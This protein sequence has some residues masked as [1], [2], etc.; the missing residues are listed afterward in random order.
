MKKYIKDEFNVLM[1]QDVWINA[2]RHARRSYNPKTGKHSEYYTGLREDDITGVCVDYW[3]VTEEMIRMAT[4]HAE[5]RKR[6]ILEEIRLN[7]NVCAFIGMGWNM[8]R[9]FP[10]HEINNYRIRCYIWIKNPK[11]ISKKRDE[12]GFIEFSTTQYHADGR[13]R[14]LPYLMFDANHGEEQIPIKHGISHLQPIVYNKENVL[15]ILKNV[16]GVKFDDIKVYNYFVSQDD[17]INGDND[18]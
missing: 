8:E 1:E 13:D 12:V 15:S 16:M 6:E 5:R 7:P 10:N 9:D 3:G 2:F 18:V 4:E 11:S 14:T 17:F